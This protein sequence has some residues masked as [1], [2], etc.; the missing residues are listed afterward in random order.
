MTSNAG[1]RERALNLSLLGNALALLALAALAAALARWQADAWQ[2]VAPGRGR[3]WMAAAL[4]A[5]YAG[6]VAAVARA[7]RRSA[8]RE[9]LPAIHADRRGD[10]LVAFASQT[11]FAEQ[12]ARRSWQ[13]LR[14]AG[15]NADLAVLGTLDAAQLAHY[16]RALFVVSTTGEGD[17]P[18]SA[19]AFVRKAMGAATP[20]P[21][22]GFGVLALGDREYVEYCAFGHRLDHWLRHAGAQPLFDLVEVDNGDAGALRHWQHHL[23]LLAG[24]TDLPDWSAPAYAP[25]RLRERRIANP[26]SA[27]AAAFHLALV[28]ADGSALQWRAGDIAEIGPRNP[29]D[30]VAQWLAANGFDGAARVRRDGAETALADLL[31][32]SRLPAAA[33]ARGQSAQAL[34]DALAPLP[35]REY[36]IASVPADGALRLLVRQMRRDDGRLGLGS[37]WLTKHAGDGAAIDLRIRTN[38][39]FHAPDDARPLILIG[40]GTGLAGLRALLRERIDA[41]HRRNWLLFGERNAA[42]DLH[43]RDELEAWLADGRLERADYAFSRDGAQRVYV[44]DRVRERIDQ[45]REWV[46][47]GAAVYVCGSLE[48]MAPAVDAVLREALGDEALEAMAAQGRYR[49]DVY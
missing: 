9:A 18:D 19:A 40:N 3:W 23:G 2:W 28:P 49:R 10:W 42:C 13:A 46:D 16:R 48:G 21:Q 24:R 8:R 30:E 14:D 5:A 11:G 43:Y 36:S 34:A 7:R 20:L 35:H 17:A 37:G 38:P 33:D 25:W 47:A 29:A 31:Q 44:Q 6:F 39:S 15:L 26:G 32:R 1:A 22:L 12:L 45:V 27:G 4:V 41:G